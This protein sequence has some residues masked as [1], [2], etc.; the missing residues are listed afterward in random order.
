MVETTAPGKLFFTGEWSILENNNLCIVLPVKKFVTVTIKQ[1]SKFKLNAQDINIENLEFVF[2]NQKLKFKN[3]LQKKDVEHLVFAHNAIKIALQYLLE[4]NCKIKKF[5]LTVKS[6][7]SR[8]KLSDN[9]FGKVGFGSSA[10]IVVAIISAILKFYCFDIAQEKLKSLIFKL[11]TI[12]HYK[13]QEKVG[14]GADIAT[15]TYAQPIIYKKFDGEWLLQQLESNSKLT[16]IVNASWPY[17]Q[18]TPINLPKNMTILVGFTGKSASTKKLIFEI[19]KLKNKKTTK[20]YTTINSI[21]NCVTNLIEAI[22]A[23]NQIKILNYINKNR[24]LL[25]QLYPALETIELTKLI[26]AAN[27]HGVA[28]KFSGAGGGDCGIAICFDKTVA[29][30]VVDEWER[31]GICFV[32]V[33]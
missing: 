13:A 14:S 6:E 9:T 20:Y 16:S 4:N 17:L 23:C 26:E 22:K 15:S 29:Q 3:K 2:E 31:I 8:I 21:D 25:K 24:D 18:I 28:A 7:I 5:E 12:A 19:Q 11:S 32:D 30:K 27:T 1:S 33:L 10:A